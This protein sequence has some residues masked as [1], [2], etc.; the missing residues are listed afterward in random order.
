MLNCRAKLSWL[1]WWSPQSADCLL[2]LCRSFLEAY[3]WKQQL[4]APVFNKLDACLAPL[5][6]S[7]ATTGSTGQA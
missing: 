6:L 1:C 2:F 4:E 3:K 5:A 7:I